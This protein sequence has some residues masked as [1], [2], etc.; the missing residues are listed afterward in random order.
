MWTAEGPAQ[1]WVGP[2]WTHVAP[3]NQPQTHLR[4]Q[5][6]QLGVTLVSRIILPDRC[7]DYCSETSR[8][9]PLK[10]LSTFIPTN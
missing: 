1:E 5:T 4:V 7:L 9:K 6:D 10:Y 2:T 8:A 3:L